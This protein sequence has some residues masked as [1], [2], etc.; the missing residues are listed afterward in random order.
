MLLSLG[1]AGPLSI[2]RDMGHETALTQATKR[3]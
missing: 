1:E 2:T 3:V